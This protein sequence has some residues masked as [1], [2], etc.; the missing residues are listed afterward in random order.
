M[1]SAVLVRRRPIRITFSQAF[2]ALL[3]KQEAAHQSLTHD[4][5]HAATIGLAKL[6]QIEDVTELDETAQLHRFIDEANTHSVMDAIHFQY[7]TISVSED[8]LDE[9][10]LIKLTH[11][12][13]LLQ[14]GLSDLSEGSLLVLAATAGLHPH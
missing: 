2:E 9:L 5:E 4:L 3:L 11:G 1:T 10:E 6:Q 12:E 7:W 14:L 13:D 8:I